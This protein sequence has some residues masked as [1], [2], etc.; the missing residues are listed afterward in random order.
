MKY[1]RNIS[2]KHLIYLKIKFG[3]YIKV[4]TSTECTVYCKRRQEDILNNY[5]RG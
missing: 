2:E 3:E 1:H 4:C 5:L